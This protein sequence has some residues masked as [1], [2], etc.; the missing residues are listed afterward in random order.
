MFV[1]R[2]AGIAG[3][4]YGAV[5]LLDDGSV[6][7]RTGSTPYGQGH[8]TAWAMLV[9]DRLGIAMEQITVVHGDTDLIPRGGITGGSRSAQK[10]GTAVAQAADALVVA[11]RTAAAALLEASVDDVVLELDGGGRFHV[12]GVPSRGV[13][14]SE[15]ATATADD[16]L[17]CEA[18]FDAEG[19]SCPHGAYVCVVE[20]DADTGGVTIERMV[21]VDD[22]G[23]ILNPLLAEGQVHGGLGQG[24]S[25]ALFE[26]LS[27]TTR[28]SPSRPAFS[29]T[30]SPSAADLPP[31]ECSKRSDRRRTTPSG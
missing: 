9:A 20:V 25:Q 22:A 23:I 31:Y 4:E 16:P 19:G 27:T 3:S 18:D 17:R 10:A 1:D 7:V 29:T 8:H 24:I 14:W 15:V 12:A 5:E 21:A 13:S 30:C 26:E 6:L 2:T 28:D 11:G